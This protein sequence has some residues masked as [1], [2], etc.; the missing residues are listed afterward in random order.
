MTLEDQNEG[1]TMLNKL[2]QSILPGYNHLW[3]FD[4]ALST[5]ESISGYQVT[6]LVTVY[7][8]ERQEMFHCFGKIYDIKS[9]ELVFHGT[10]KASAQNIKESG[11]RGATAER[12]VYGKGVYSTTDLYI[13]AQY[14]T[15]DLQGEQAIIMANIFLGPITQGRKDMTDFGT[16]AQT[17]KEILTTTN[18]TGNIFCSKFENALYADAVVTIRHRLEPPT[19]MHQKT[20]PRL[21][22]DIWKMINSPPYLTAVL[23]VPSQPV[24]EFKIEHNGLK[25]GDTVRL[26]KEITV[27]KYKT[28]EGEITGIIVSFSR[29][30]GGPWFLHLEPL[31]NDMKKKVEIAHLKSKDLLFSTQH[32]DHVRALVGNFEEISAGQKRKSSA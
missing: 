24:Q 22:P 32:R 14:A 4:S 20:F 12:S 25:V 18:D 6:S 16:D 30:K 23:P 7:N 28:I 26:N 15:P 1:L 3:H 19:E 8:K 11:F 21:H 5:F 17:G 2:I 13:A 10:S 9:T 31:R 29:N 27:Q